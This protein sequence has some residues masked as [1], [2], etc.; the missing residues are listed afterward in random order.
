MEI[1]KCIST[2]DYIYQNTIYQYNLI[3]NYAYQMLFMDNK[4]LYI[5]RILFVFAG[6]ELKFKIIQK[7]P[8]ITNSSDV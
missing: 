1:I 8:C 6:M 7:L 3:C 2:N 5:N 4:M